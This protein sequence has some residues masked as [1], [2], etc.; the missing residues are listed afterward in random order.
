MTQ[1]T[2]SLFLLGDARV[3]ALAPLVILAFLGATLGLVCA[4]LGAAVS[5]AVR[6]FGLAKWLGIGAL[7]IASGYAA[8]LFGAAL[9]SR[10]RTLAPGERKYFCE[11]DCHIAYDL[12]SAA[13]PDARTRVVTVRSWFD[14][15][16]IAAFRGDGPL[17]PNPRTVWLE[18]ETGRRFLPS[19]AGTAAWEAAH[20]NPS[21]PLSRQLR[22]GESYTTTFV[23]T[24]PA[25]ARGPR[26]FVGDPVG[27]ENLLIGHENSP[28]HGKVYFA[29]P[30]PQ[31]AGK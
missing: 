1:S 27:P 10:D 11:M 15:G 5:A 29:L 26:L 6:R 12:T 4:S 30:A 14:P 3:P 20:G 19:V 24:L 2:L 21:A 16:T 8:L 9:F 23:F 22:P 25:D 7:A 28:L 17:S 18:D 31:A 13:A